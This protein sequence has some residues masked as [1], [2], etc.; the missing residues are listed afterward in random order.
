MSTDY[1]RT[2]QTIGN[3]ALMLV[4]AATQLEQAQQDLQHAEEREHDLLQSVEEWRQERDQFQRMYSDQQQEAEK[5]R[6][7]V[8]ALQDFP[9]TTMTDVARDGLLH[10]VMQLFHYPERWEQLRAY[11]QAQTPLMSDNKIAMIKRVREITQW[12]LKESKNF[13]ESYPNNLPISPREDD[14]EAGDIIFPPA[15]Q[16]PY[17]GTP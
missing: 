16:P 10:A 6:H 12:G 14:E 7:Q 9:P 17:T 3:L 13:V 15:Y 4:E 2:V 8:K 5:L 11:M 1:T